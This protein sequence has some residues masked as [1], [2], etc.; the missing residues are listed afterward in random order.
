MELKTS[1]LVIFVAVGIVVMTLLVLNMAVKPEVAEVLLEKYKSGDIPE[2]AYKD[3]I[4]DGEITY[5]E[6]IP[7]EVI[8][9][10]HFTFSNK[11]W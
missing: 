3:A 11:L 7:A 4:S 10:T 8:P 9:P 6:N 5:W 1:Y 2:K